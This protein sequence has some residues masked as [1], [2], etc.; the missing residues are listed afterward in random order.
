MDS[1]LKKKSVSNLKLVVLDAGGGAYFFLAMITTSVR[2]PS[3]HGSTEVFVHDIIYF[4]YDVCIRSTSYVATTNM[5]SEARSRS[6]GEA[7]RTVCCTTIIC[8]CNRSRTRCLL[9]TY[10]GSNFY[11]LRVNR[12]KWFISLPVQS[13]L[14]SILVTW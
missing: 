3:T 11:P 1:L 4:V 8:V 5:I 2:V 9:R 14:C 6:T 12:G 10:S 13:N 7:V